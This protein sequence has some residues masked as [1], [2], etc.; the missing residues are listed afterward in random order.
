MAFERRRTKQWSVTRRR[1]TAKC[2]GRGGEGGKR[3]C[4]RP[5][6]VTCTS[7]KEVL[8]AYH[9]RDHGRD[10]GR[11]VSMTVVCGDPAPYENGKGGKEGGGGPTQKVTPACAR[12]RS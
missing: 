2:Q 1:S 7:T 6:A 12:V 10:R 4:A 5:R 11:D 9:G 3:V 8:D